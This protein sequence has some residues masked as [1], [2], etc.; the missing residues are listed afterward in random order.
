MAWQL[1]DFHLTLHTYGAAAAVGT[2]LDLHCQLCVAR[3]GVQEEDS[4]QQRV[5]GCWGG[6]VLAR[7]ATSVITRG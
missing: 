1:A 3:R 4:T 6:W 5:G 2:C 7:I